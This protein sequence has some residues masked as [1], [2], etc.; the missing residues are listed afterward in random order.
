MTVEKGQDVLQDYEFGE[1]NMAHKVKSHLYV[2]KN[3]AIADTLTA[4]YS[5]VPPA[6]LQ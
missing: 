3:E 2:G 1:K 6:E 4:C 5:S